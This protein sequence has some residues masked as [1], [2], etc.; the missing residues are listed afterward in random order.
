[1]ADALVTV[2]ACVHKACLRIE[3]RASF[4]CKQELVARS[5]GGVER[6]RTAQMRAEADWT[7]SGYFDSCGSTETSGESVLSFLIVLLAFLTIS[8]L[9]AA[10]AGARLNLE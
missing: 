6:H 7:V 1:M 8:E 2:G 5:N 4:R 3:P 10:A 9:R